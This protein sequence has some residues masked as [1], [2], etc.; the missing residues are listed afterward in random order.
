MRSQFLLSETRG[1]LEFNH[2]GTQTNSP[3]LSASVVKKSYGAH[4]KLRRALF[5]L[6]RKTDGLGAS[7]KFPF[8][9]SSSKPVV[10][11]DDNAF[12]NLLPVQWSRQA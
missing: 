2:R 3:C 11:P 8:A 1:Q 12:F 5:D 7:P 4:D 6:L 9:L 10:G